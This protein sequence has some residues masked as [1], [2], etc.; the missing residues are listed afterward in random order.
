V[1]AQYFDCL[2]WRMAQE[3]IEMMNGRRNISN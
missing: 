2:S 3:L 1:D